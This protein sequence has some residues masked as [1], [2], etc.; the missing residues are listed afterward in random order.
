M[1]DVYKTK[2][3]LAVSGI[4][5]QIITE[6]L[7]ALVIE[8]RWIPDEIRLITTTQGRQNA[9]LQLLEGNNHLKRFLEDYGI[10]RP[11]RFDSDHIV[12][13]RNAKGEELADLRTPEDNEAAANTICSIIRELTQDDNTE[14]HVSLAGGRKTMGFYAGY[15][16]SLFGRTQDRLS[17]VLVSDLYESNH[18]FFYPTP[19]T[20]VIYTPQG[21]PLDSSQAKVWLAEI[22]FVRLRAR[23]PETLLSGAHSFSETVNLARKA[24]EEPPRL[25]L[26]P[27]QRRYQMN[28][29][30]GQLSP[31]PMAILLWLAVRKLQQRG[32]I[33]PVV[34]KED[35]SADLQELR[36]ILAEYNLDLNQ[37]TESK[38]D[39]EGLTREWLEQTVSRTNSEM[40]K[41]L[42]LDL[43]EQCKITSC[44]IG[45]RR[46]YMFPEH[47]QV[48]IH[49]QWTHD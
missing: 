30:E 2:V 9:V 7:Y 14:L 42:G 29:V 6:T 3:L 39:Q 43:S 49:E 36:H 25:K 4:S 31:A 35:R 23:L 18:E 16:L 24:T 38:L 1:T 44:N 13:I 33:E 27:E 26:Y 11:I 32:P 34:E 12:L 22:P 10:E 17:H 5:P 46:G 21:T 28:G 41:V 45:H 48:D 37:K 19:A 8:K 20:R 40:K 15:A 47:L